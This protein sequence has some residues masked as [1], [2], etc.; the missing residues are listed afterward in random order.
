MVVTPDEFKPKGCV[1]IPSGYLKPGP[2]PVV[3]SVSGARVPVVAFLR[4]SV[5]M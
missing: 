1:K 2:W 3:V 4:V 5:P